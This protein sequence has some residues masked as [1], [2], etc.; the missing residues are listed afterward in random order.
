MNCRPGLHYAQHDDETCN[1]PTVPYKTQQ[2]IAYSIGTNEWKL[3]NNI[4]SSEFVGIHVNLM[5]CK[6]NHG[7]QSNIITGQV[8]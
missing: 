4:N 3:N 6:F 2:E 5:K 1:N 8:N 7:M